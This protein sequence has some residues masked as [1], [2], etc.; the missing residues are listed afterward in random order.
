MTQSPDECAGRVLEVVPQVMRAIRAE[1]RTRRAADLSVS[2]FR[3]LAFI[4]RREGASLSDVAGHI[5]LALPSMSKM[6]DG[7]VARNLVRR[8]TRPRDRRS[9]TLSLTQPG[10]ALHQSARA[11]AQRFL[12][13]RLAALR[14]ADRAAVG[15]AMAVLR[16]LFMSAGEDDPERAR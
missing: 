5:G 4:A 8:E 14:P 6:I 1:M 11:A 15:Q 3:A 13:E 10:R 12:T 7:L 2:Q 16:P 9:V